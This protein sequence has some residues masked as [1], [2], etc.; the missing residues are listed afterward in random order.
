M[1]SVEMKHVSGSNPDRLTKEITMNITFHV[2]KP[3]D[4]FDNMID[5]ECC[6]FSVPNDY[7][8]GFHQCTRKPTQE[9]EGYKFCTQHS[10][11]LKELGY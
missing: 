5:L 4:R 7:G 3:N 2:Y 9:I 1:F 6:R 11:I 10:K 8:V